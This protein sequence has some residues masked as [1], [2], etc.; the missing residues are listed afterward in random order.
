[1]NVNYGK[2]LT[3]FILPN[4]S[5][6]DSFVSVSKRILF[7]VNLFCLSVYGSIVIIG[8]IILYVLTTFVSEVN[9]VIYLIKKRWKCYTVHFNT[10]IILDSNVEEL[11]C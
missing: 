6:L 4:P 9:C 3:I 8:I 1:M 10:G 7:N 5:R 11:D 2:S